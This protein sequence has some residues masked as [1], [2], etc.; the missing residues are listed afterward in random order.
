[1]KVLHSFKT[2]G[3]NN[4]SL[5]FINSENLDLVIEIFQI[6]AAGDGNYVACQ[7]PMH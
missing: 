2:F 1:M 6:V 3:V 5:Q 4:S 7:S